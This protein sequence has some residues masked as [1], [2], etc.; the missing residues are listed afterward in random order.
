MYQMYLCNVG[1]LGKNLLVFREGEVGGKLKEFWEVE[2]GGKYKDWENV[3]KE[4]TLQAK[5]VFITTCSSGM[6]C[7]LTLS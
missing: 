3:S 6:L 2:S 7:S 4:R 5:L 1:C